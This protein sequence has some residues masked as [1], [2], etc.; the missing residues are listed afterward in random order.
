MENIHWWSHLLQAREFRERKLVTE[1]QK[2]PICLIR[3][4]PFLPRTPLPAPLSQDWTITFPVTIR[5]MPQCARTE[6]FESRGTTMEESESTQLSSGSL[7]NPQGSEE[8]RRW[9]K[10]SEGELTSASG[11]VCLMVP[12]PLLRR[13]R[14]CL[15]WDRA[16]RSQN[17]S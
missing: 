6:T 5:V 9:G 4:G 10:K 13:S 7:V 8:V 1:V 14:S 16:E 11:K 2:E 12:V 17:E 15:V 3:L